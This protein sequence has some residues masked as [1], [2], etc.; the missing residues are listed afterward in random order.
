MFNL[1]V[2]LICVVWFLYIHYRLKKV[3]STRIMKD[4][5]KD[6]KIKKKSS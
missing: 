1:N 6:A 4:A 3:E 5:L 2:I